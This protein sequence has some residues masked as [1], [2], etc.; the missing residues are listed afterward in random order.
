MDGVCIGTYPSN[1]FVTLHVLHVSAIV[2]NLLNV[3][4]PMIADRLAP[5]LSTGLFATFSQRT[6]SGTIAPRSV[7]CSTSKIS[8]LMADVPTYPVDRALVA[9]L[10]DEI[11]HAPDHP[12]LTAYFAENEAPKPRI[13]WDPLEHELNAEPLRFLARY[14]RAKRVGDGLPG[15]DIVDPLALKPALGYIMLLDVLDD[16]WDYRYR[17][18]GSNIVQRF[19]RDLTGKRTSDI[20]K[21]A[22]TGIFYLAG[23]RAVLERRLPLFTV[24]AS[25]KYVAAVD[26]WRLALPLAAPDGTIARLLVGNMPGDWREAREPLPPRT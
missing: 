12:R 16:G 8:S 1:D 5:G 14:W 23:Y 26:W 7:L 21:T 15:I 19:G 20:S 6:G 24:S 22:F 17:I 4:G 10:A 25:P 9:G 2:G 11:A 18:Y 13:V 3:Y